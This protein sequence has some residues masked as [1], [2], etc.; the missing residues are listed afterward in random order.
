MPIRAIRDLAHFIRVF[1]PVRFSSEHPPG[2]EPVAPESIDYSRVHDVCARIHGMVGR[3]TGRGHVVLIPLRSGGARYEFVKGV[4]R[5]LAP[6]AR[7]V[8][9]STPKSSPNAR[10]ERLSTDFVQH[11]QKALR[12]SD[13]Y[14]HVLDNVFQGGTLDRIHRAIVHLQHPGTLTVAGHTYSENL[15]SPVLQRFS[16]ALYRPIND[17][18]YSY[19]PDPH[20]HRVLREHPR[21]VNEMGWQKA[22]SGGRLFNPVGASVNPFSGEPVDR[23]LRVQIAAV[24]RHVRQLGVAYARTYLKEPKV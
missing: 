14:I 5:V 6:R 19:Y 9:L 7:V 21:D 10:I 17:A 20:T 13:Q 12:P 3:G 23:S 4:L 1:H 15:G 18:I 24:R 2:F 8:A 16:E 22:E 11:V